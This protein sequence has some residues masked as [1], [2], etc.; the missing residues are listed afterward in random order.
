MVTR[1]GGGICRVRRRGRRTSDNNGYATTD[2]RFPLSV[3]EYKTQNGRY[4]N[5]DSPVGQ[6]VSENIDKLVNYFPDSVPFERW[7]DKISS[8]DCNTAAS[9]SLPSCA[10]H[11]EK[12]YACFRWWQETLGMYG[13][14]NR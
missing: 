5:A 13:R 14:A 2:S 3:I 4:A 12:D 1:R 11:D 9:S 10:V 7:S 8:A 6:T